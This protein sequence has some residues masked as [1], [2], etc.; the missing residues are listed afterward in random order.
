[1]AWVRTWGVA[2]FATATILLFSTITLGADEGAGKGMTAVLAEARTLKAFKHCRATVWTRQIEMGMFI[3]FQSC[4]GDLFG[5]PTCF[6]EASSLNE[7][8]PFCFESFLA[9]VTGTFTAGTTVRAIR[10]FTCGA[11]R[12]GGRERG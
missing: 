10:V 9:G 1:M 11:L 3:S 8:V 6:T 7:N 12:V 4:D 2:A 5:D